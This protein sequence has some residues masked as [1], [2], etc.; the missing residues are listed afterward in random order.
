MEQILLA[1]VL[2]HTGDMEVIWDNQHGFAKGK[3]C[4]TSLV[5]FYDG[6]TPSVDKGRA[7]DV[8]YL[9]FHKAFDTVPHNT[10]PP[11]LERER[12]LSPMMC[13][14]SKSRT[15]EKIM[16]QILLADVL[17]HTGDMEVIWDN[18]HGFAKGKSCLTSL[19]A[20]YDGLTPSVD[21]GRAADVIYLDFHKA[22]D[23][24]P[25]NTLPPKL[26]RERFLSPMM[27]GLSSE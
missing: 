11:K 13:G 14:L 5:A 19:V 12:F 7:A 24:V 9:D 6:L 15:L 17:R 26:E 10:L 4:L 22:F 25:H 2:R 1:D 21:K 8:I 23:T 27:C 3:S 16:E 18:Q 20:F